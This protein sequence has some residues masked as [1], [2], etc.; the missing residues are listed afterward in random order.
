MP[1]MKSAVICRN[2]TIALLSPGARM[3]LFHLAVTATISER[4]QR[5]VY[6]RSE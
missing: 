3:G 5:Y 2:A 4:S 6:E 1:S